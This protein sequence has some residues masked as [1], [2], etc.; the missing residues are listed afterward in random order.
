MSL[1]PSKEFLLGWFL[2]AVCAL[3]AAL[4]REWWR[5]WTDCV[6]ELSKYQQLFPTAFECAG[7]GG[8]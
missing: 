8:S 2:G 3:G 7:C 5:Q 1:L 6:E 4:F